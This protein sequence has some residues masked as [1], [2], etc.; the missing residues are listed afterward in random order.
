MLGVAVAAIVGVAARVGLA[1]PATVCVTAA[2]ADGVTPGV[3]VAAPASGVAVT[4][5]TTCVG[6]CAWHAVSS[7][8]RTR[9]KDQ[10]R[11]GM[12]TPSMGEQ[13]TTHTLIKE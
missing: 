2:L 8:R 1:E 10:M 5:R 7:R 9:D 6:N 11:S 13:L 12:T 4:T 3:T